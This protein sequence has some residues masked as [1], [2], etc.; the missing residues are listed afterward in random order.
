MTERITFGDVH[1]LLGEFGFEQT[2]VKGSHVLF[3]HKPSGTV[4]AFR[5]HRRNERIDPMTLAIVRSVLVEN[6]F[7]EREDFETALREA[8]ANGRARAKGE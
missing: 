4:V 6:G 2:P 7:L 3:E 5:P 1:H 8:S